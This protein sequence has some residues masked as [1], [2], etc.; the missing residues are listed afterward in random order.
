MSGARR[1]TGCQQ[2]VQD[3][4]QAIRQFQNRQVWPSLATAYELTGSS[5]FEIFLQGTVAHFCQK[6]LS[7]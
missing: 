6:S 2:A 7:I 5:R 4:H 3:C 1:R